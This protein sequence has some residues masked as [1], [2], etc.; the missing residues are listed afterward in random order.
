MNLIDLHRTQKK[1]K[2]G[3][4]KYRKTVI[5][6]LCYGAGYV[7]FKRDNPRIPARLIA[8]VSKLFSLHHLY[9]GRA[10]QPLIKCMGKNI[11]QSCFH[12]EVQLW[13]N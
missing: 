7:K 8:D 6:A 3:R 12:D 13:K 4:G 10:T 1:R 11:V 5:F 2:I 9:K